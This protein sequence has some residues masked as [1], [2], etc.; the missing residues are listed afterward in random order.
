M[1]EREEVL[2]VPQCR[3]AAYRIDFAV[4]GKSTSGLPI[5]VGIECDGREFHRKPHQVRRD[6]MRDRFLTDLGVTMKR[7]QGWEIHKDP[8]GCARSALQPIMTA[9]RWPM[10]RARPDWL[11]R[12][13]Q[14]RDEL[15][16]RRNYG[17]REYATP[18]WLELEIGEGGDE[19]L[20]HHLLNS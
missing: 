8:E 16:W 18:D 15:K 20:F 13:M 3:A 5:I 1:F 17:R 4:F 6:Q 11:D 14:R 10:S 12:E 9:Q 19:R 2:I 7:Y